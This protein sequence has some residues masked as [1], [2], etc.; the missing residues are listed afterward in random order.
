MGWYSGNSGGETHDVGGKQA[1]DFGLHDMHGNVFEWCEDVYNESFYDSEFSYGPDPLSTGG[2]EFRVIRGGSW[3]LNATICRSADRNWLTPVNRLFLIGFRP[4]RPLPIEP[5]LGCTAPEASNYNADATQEDG[6]CESEE[7]DPVADA[8]AFSL[9]V[10]ETYFDPS[11]QSYQTFLGY[12]ND[13][14][15]V[16]WGEGPFNKADLTY[17]DSHP[18]GRDYS[19]YTME[20]YLEVYSPT[21]YAYDEA[22]AQYPSLAGQIVGNWVYNEEDYLFLGA[23]TNPDQTSFIWDDILVFVV[24]KESGEWKVIAFDG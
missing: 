12:L 15:Y 13:E 1:N 20:D 19:P 4:A 3:D 6:S 16:I 23:K 17:E 9:L 7:T 10:V 21:I 5:L 8:L 14:L 11:E 18:F 24:T 22:I 2:S